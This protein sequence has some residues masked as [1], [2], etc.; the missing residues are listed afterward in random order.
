[1]NTLE[2]IHNFRKY[3]KHIN[4]LDKTEPLSVEYYTI[5][6]D[7][8]IVTFPTKAQLFDFM[9]RCDFRFPMYKRINQKLIS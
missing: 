5:L 7:N 4:K 2:S 8:Q 3:H 6:N 1:M 9:E